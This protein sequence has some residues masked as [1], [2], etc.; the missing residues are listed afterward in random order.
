VPHEANLGRGLAGS[1]EVLPVHQRDHQDGHRHGHRDP[2]TAYR[3]PV[4]RWAGVAEGR[5][6]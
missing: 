1:A 6:H 5:S 2:H 3:D 4:K